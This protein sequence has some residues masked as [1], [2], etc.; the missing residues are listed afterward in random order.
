MGD[1]DFIIALL[2]LLVEFHHG[3]ESHKFESFPRRSEAVVGIILVVSMYNR[4]ALE[5]RGIDFT[6]ELAGVSAIDD[7]RTHEPYRIGVILVGYIEYERSAECYLDAVEISH[8][9]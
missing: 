5:I 7:D 3:S 4:I 8:E 9:Q 1:E 2:Q 6:L